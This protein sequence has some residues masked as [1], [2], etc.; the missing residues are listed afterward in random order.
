MKKKICL[1]MLTFTLLISITGC[2]TNKQENS[3]NKKN[4]INDINQL[5]LSAE[6]SKVTKVDDN[7]D[8]DVKQQDVMDQEKELDEETE[9]FLYG[10]WEVAE[11]LGHPGHYTDGR[12]TDENIINKKIIIEEDFYSS[13]VFSEYSSFQIET[14]S[15]KYKT[16]IITNNLGDFE[17]V[18]R[19]D[20]S[21]FNITNDDT[22]KMLILPDTLGI[23]IN[24][25]RL[26]FA[27]AGAEY[28][29][30]KKLE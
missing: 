10:T 11:Y 19:T 3:T 18:Y 6:K 1:V 13:K 15:P 14:S 2:N 24:N 23:I 30:L 22:V 4:I 7:V 12:V 25:N 9:A 20:P 8:I 28:F 16:S 5:D 17:L 26:I 29:E 27:F 21:I